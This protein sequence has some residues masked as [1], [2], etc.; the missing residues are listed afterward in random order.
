MPLKRR[1]G[2]KTWLQEIE[3]M[4]WPVQ[5]PC[6]PGWEENGEPQT[7]HH[8][9][10]SRLITRSPSQDSVAPPAKRGRSRCSTGTDQ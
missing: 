7:S 1:V 2:S 8:H 4:W 6:P 3:I 5:E 10:Y 9:H